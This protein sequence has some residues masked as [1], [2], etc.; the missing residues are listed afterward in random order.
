M[1]SQERIGCHAAP[2][3]GYISISLTALPLPDGHGAIR[4]SG[5]ERGWSDVMDNGYS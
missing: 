2:C 5:C 1:K 3:K 4:E